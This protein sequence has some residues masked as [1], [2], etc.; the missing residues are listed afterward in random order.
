MIMGQQSRCGKERVAVSITCTP[1]SFRPPPADASL[2]PAAS[3]GR[4][5]S[6]R[7]LHGGLDERVDDGGPLGADVRAGEEPVAPTVA[8]PRTA[9]LNGAVVELQR[10][11]PL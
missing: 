1:A 8:M 3:S 6:P 5:P 11:V 4:P 10:A 9:P 7:F 2:R